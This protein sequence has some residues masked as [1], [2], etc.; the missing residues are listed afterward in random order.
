MRSFSKT[1]HV[2]KKSR[3]VVNGVYGTQGQDRSEKFL[4]VGVLGSCLAL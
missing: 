4:I 1:Y 2:T 3:S